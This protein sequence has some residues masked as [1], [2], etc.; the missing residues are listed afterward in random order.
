MLANELPNIG[1]ALSDFF[2][3]ISGESDGAAMF[4]AGALQSL[5][6]F[7]RGSGEVIAWLSG[8]FD[9]S[10]RAS[11]SLSG[12]LED[13]LGW[14]PFWGDYVADSNDK[15]E[16]MIDALERGKDASGDFAGGVV[17]IGESAEETAGKVQALKDGIDEL[18]GITMSLDQATLAYKRG[19]ADL[20]KELTEG[21]RTLDENTVAGQDNIETILGRITELENL[22]KA[23]ANSNIG[24]DAANRLYEKHLEQLRKN[25]IQLGYN[26]TAVNAIIDRYKAI[27]KTVETNLKLIISTYGDVTAWSMIRNQER[28]QEEAAGKRAAGGPVRKGNAYWVGE[29]GPELVT[30]GENGMVHSAADSRAMMSGASGGSVASM[31]AQEIRLI[32]DIR[33]DDEDQVR[34]IRKQ[35]EVLGG[36]N[37]QVAFGSS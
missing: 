27:P 4:L 23:Q 24:V 34:R 10:V 11:A 5:Q 32:I 12:F 14:V 25:L 30:F 33:G 3:T 21:K 35:V 37:V 6:G 36:G 2:T 29:N 1:S 16:G 26:T 13:A 15:L 18:F 22:R 20:N 28:Q 7:I 8:I 31:G 19:F 9:W 17:R